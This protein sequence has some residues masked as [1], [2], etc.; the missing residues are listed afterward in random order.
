M[1]D[2]NHKLLTIANKIVK[3]NLNNYPNRNIV[4]RLLKKRSSWKVVETNKL[5]LEND[6][7][8]KINKLSNIHNKDIKT[9]KKLLINCKFFLERL[10]ILINKEISQRLLISENKL[11][12]IRNIHIPK[13]SKINQYLYNNILNFNLKVKDINSKTNLE[14]L[15]Q[16]KKEI[17]LLIDDLNI[18]YKTKYKIFKEKRIILRK[19]LDNNKKEFELRFYKSNY[20]ISEVDNYII[21]NNPNQMYNKDFILELNNKYWDQEG[22]YKYKNMT[23]YIVFLNDIWFK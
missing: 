22:K 8:I 17:Q 13:D 3:H 23:E 16:N 7:N 12:K 20:F 2:K 9:L 5:Y 11:L 19:C 10:N 4:E 6:F 18:H 1:N 15:K 21:I 14:I